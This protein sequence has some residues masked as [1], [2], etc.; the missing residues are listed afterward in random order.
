[1]DPMNIVGLMIKYLAWIQ[2]VNL[3]LILCKYI[4]HHA[5]GLHTPSITN[6]SLNLKQS[7]HFT[8]KLFLH[9]Q[10]IIVIIVLDIVGTAFLSQEAALLMRSIEVGGW[11]YYLQQQQ[12]NLLWK[13]ILQN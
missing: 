12:K 3:G 2:L 8:V 9:C 6:Y 7:F 1:M 13:V 4:V 11:R 10:N 5:F